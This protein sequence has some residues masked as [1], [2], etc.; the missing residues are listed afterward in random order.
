[1]VQIKARKVYDVF[2]DPM[3]CI[4]SLFADLYCFLCEQISSVQ[5]VSLE[6][7]YVLPNSLFYF[8]PINDSYIK[9]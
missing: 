9:M 1:M 2:M 3:G 7:S 6:H 5:A 8:I 4:I